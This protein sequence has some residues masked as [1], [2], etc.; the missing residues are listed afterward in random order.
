MKKVIV[1]LNVLLV[2]ACI[3][4]ITL[5][6]ML[7]SEDDILTRRDISFHYS[8]NKKLS[9]KLRRDS[10]ELT[11]ALKMNSNSRS[12]RCTSVSEA[13]QIY[14][15]WSQRLLSTAFRNRLSSIRLNASIDSVFIIDNMVWSNSSPQNPY[16]SPEFTMRERNDRMTPREILKLENIILSRY[17]AMTGQLNRDCLLADSY[18]FFETFEAFL[19]KGVDAPWL[20]DEMDILLPESL[21]VNETERVFISLNK[22]AIDRVV[23]SLQQAGLI[24]ANLTNTYRSQI[25]LVSQ[26]LKI[27]AIGFE[28]QP[29]T[30]HETTTWEFDIT[31]SDAVKAPIIIQVGLILKDR[32]ENIELK[33]IDLKEKPMTIF[34]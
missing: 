27:R 18:G 24:D 25:R 4:L 11:E 7:P 21:V 16:Q 17:A 33:F 14:F 8:V 28:E 15:K 9:D 6:K 23:D 29:V 2:L 5:N 12:I 32:N 26:D 20:S 3:L 34:D 30:G 1:F 13:N 22:K 19:S 10:Y 31:A